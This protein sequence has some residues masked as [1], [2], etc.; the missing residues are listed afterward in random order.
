M[1]W[2]IGDCKMPEQSF[3]ERLRPHLTDQS[4]IAFLKMVCQPDK[5]EKLGS[6]DDLIGKIDAWIGNSKAVRHDGERRLADTGAHFAAG[7]ADEQIESADATRR[8]GLHGQKQL[9]SLR[10][11][12]EDL[13]ERNLI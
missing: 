13:R 7:N 11:H 3:F 1:I 4:H 5:P 6:Y 9:A 8:I 10:A 2:K 12:L